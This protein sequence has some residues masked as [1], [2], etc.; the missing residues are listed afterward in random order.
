MNANIIL[1]TINSNK[2]NFEYFGIRAM[3]MNPTTNEYEIAEVGKSI[4]YS[5]D[6]NDGETTED[7]LN[8]ACAIK[9]DRDAEISDIENAINN[10]N[11]YDTGSQVVLLGSDRRD[12]G[13]DSNEIVMYNHLTVIAIL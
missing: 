11:Y 13:S 10:L 1:D 2:E 6:W 12:Y 8:G 7:Q 3:T 9:I 4:S 5:Y